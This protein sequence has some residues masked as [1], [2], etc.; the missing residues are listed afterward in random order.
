VMDQLQSRFQVDPVEDVQVLTAMR[1]G[2]IG[3]RS[4]NSVLQNHFNRIEPGEEGDNST[5]LPLQDPSGVYAF[6]VGD[7][8]MQIVND[9]YR[10]VFNGEIGRV[11]GIS[12]VPGS[13]QVRFPS[14]N[15]NGSG[16]RT[17]EYTLDELR[18]IEPSFACTIHKSQGCEFP[19]AILPVHSEY[20]RVLQRNL[21]YT[22]ITRGAKLTILVGNMSAVDHAIAKTEANSRKSF[23][24]QRLVERFS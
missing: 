12:H 11:V 22:G 1:K 21:L 20:S 9:Y 13:L 19:V 24:K 2:P 4:F 17:V 5:L 10:D 18:D 8:V 15:G 6:R 7:K 14:S 3:S 16:S 23:L